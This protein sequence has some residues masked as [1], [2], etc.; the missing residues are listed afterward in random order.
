MGGKL[1]FAVQPAGAEAPS[2]ETP[3]LL[4]LE[5]VLTISQIADRLKIDRHVVTRLF[6]SERRVICIGS[7]ETR[8]GKRKYR[9]FRVPVS[10]YKRVVARLS[11]K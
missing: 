4:V 5:P 11:N 6:A 2:Q 9:T 1:K 10:V 3:S 7:P 8:Y